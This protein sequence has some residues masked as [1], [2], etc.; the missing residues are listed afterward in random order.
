[1]NE[2]QLGRLFQAF[3]QANSSTTRNFGGTGLGLTIT[4][5][6]ATLLGGTIDVA[7]K[8][9]EGSTFTMTLPDQSSLAA[10]AAADMK[11]VLESGA[12]TSGLTVLVVD[13]DPTVHE[14]LSPSL[15][16]EGYRVLQARDGA[17][18]LAVM[19]KTPPDIVTLD[20]MMPNVD[21]WT[22]L[23]MMK[24]DPALDQ[25]PVIMVTIV[26]DRNLGFTLGR[27][28]I[29]D[30]ADRSDAV[31]GPG[32]GFHQPEAAIAGADRR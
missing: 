31:A 18:A 27:V 14:L 11:P 4:R 23:G 17:E 24:S 30:Q 9:G 25:I 12:G 10:P 3:T 21:G 1:M 19:R 26:D 28:G 2:E 5:H 6:F 16:K 15:V 29:H 20:V 7:S 8:P 32:A 22:V 13:D